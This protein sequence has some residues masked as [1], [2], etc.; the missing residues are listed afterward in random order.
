LCGR[1]GG[2]RRC[3]RGREE[4]E[5]KKKGSVVW[6]KTHIEEQYQTVRGD[7]IQEQWMYEAEDRE[8]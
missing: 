6:A 8:S 5:E 7:G 4:V 3:G 2:R 1:S